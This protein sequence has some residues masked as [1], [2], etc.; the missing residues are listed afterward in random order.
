ME[1]GI[2]KVP[3]FLRELLRRQVRGHFF[4]GTRTGTEAAGAGTK[5]R[6]GENNDSVKARWFFGLDAP[7]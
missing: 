6:L 3:T 7:L 4:L 1:S 5:H 2:A